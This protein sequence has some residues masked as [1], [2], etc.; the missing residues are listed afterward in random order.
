MNRCALLLALLWPLSAAGE[1]TSADTAREAVYQVL[2]L[3]DAATTAD[4]HNDPE[5]REVGPAKLFLGSQ[6]GRMDTAAFFAATAGLHYLVS[7][8]LTG[9]YRR[10]WQ[11]VTIGAS[12]GFAYNNLSLGLRWGFK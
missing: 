5:T 10:A 3:A 1:W 8:Q 6:P 9:A 7:R 11:Y 12:G 2:H 4:I